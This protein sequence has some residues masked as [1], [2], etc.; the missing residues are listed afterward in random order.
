MV[1]ETLP[2]PI[3]APEPMPVAPI[4]LPKLGEYPAAGTDAAKDQWLRLADLTVREAQRA[5]SWAA[6]TTSAAATLALAAANAGMAEQSGSNTAALSPL[7]E[8]VV[9]QWAAHDAALDRLTAAL[10]GL[11]QVGGGAAGGVSS[12]DFV[13]ILTALLKALAVK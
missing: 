12:D 6:S 2:A 11:P 3:P 7:I 4:V 8:Q 13:A 10:A 1:N 5:T 9:G